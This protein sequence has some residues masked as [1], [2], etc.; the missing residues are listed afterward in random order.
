MKNVK[1]KMEEKIVELKRI[2]SAN[3]NKLEPE[4]VVQEA[5]S[6]DSPLHKYFEWDDSVA[7]QRW[8]VHQARMMI[9]LSVEF[10]PGVKTS[11]EVKVFVSLRDERCEGYRTIVQVM[12]DEENREQ[13]LMDALA[14]LQY[15][16]KKYAVL[17][18]LSRIFESIDEVNNTIV[19][20]H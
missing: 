6:D 11:E 1:P 19:I 10:I 16:K 18:E 7:G 8:R 12:S 4:V 20:K 2:A 9:A 14:E 5:S 15:F 17:K 13:L 3:D